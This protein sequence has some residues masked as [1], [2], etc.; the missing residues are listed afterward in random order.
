MKHIEEQSAP[1]THYGNRVT[2]ALTNCRMYE[3]LKIK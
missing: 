1:A 3:G 2:I